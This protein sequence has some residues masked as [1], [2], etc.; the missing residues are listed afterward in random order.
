MSLHQYPF[1]PGT[2]SNNE[3]GKYNNILNIPLELG[4]PLENI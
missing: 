2:G 3:R 4:P 1:Y